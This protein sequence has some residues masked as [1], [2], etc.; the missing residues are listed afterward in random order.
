MDEVFEYIH[1]CNSKDLD[2]FFRLNME[3]ETREEKHNEKTKQNE[4][5]VKKTDN[6]QIE[7]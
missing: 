2:D 1:N 7:K 5:D 4:K 3:M 6:K